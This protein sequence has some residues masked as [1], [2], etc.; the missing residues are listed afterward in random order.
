MSD[1]QQ[2]NALE[3]TQALQAMEKRLQ[4]VE[5]KCAEYSSLVRELKSDVQAEKQKRIKAMI[6]EMGSGP[7]Q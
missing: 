4:E 5:K 6:A 2:R 7:T 1:L 3:V